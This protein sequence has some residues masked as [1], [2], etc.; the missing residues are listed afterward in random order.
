MIHYSSWALN[1]LGGK[2]PSANC[3]VGA[4]R[5]QSRADIIQV[6]VIQR[7]CT[8]VTSLPHRC[9]HV[10]RN[11]PLVRVAIGFDRL[12]VPL[13]PSATEGFK[14]LR[15]IQVSLTLGFRVAKHRLFV[16]APSGD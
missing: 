11:S 6:L 8:Q 5:R 10:S 12:A 13:P 1:G 2:R 15:H 9:F 7:N 3:V 4:W 16:K 14:K